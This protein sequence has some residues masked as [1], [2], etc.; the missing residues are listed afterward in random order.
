M[1]MHGVKPGWT[2]TKGWEGC[3]VE[4]NVAFRDVKPE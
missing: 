3:T 4:A 2:M 1:V